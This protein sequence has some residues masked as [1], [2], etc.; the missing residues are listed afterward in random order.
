M[1]HQYRNSVQYRFEIW[2][3][4]STRSGMRK[5]ARKMV[6]RIIS[7]RLSAAGYPPAGLRLAGPPRAMCSP[8][9]AV[10]LVRDDQRIGQLGPVRLGHSGQCGMRPAGIHT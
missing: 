1:K 3:R 2:V 4:L 8:G 6:A 10:G 9:L 5:R 7:G